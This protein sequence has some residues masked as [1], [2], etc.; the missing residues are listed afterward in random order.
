MGLVTA[1]TDRV[2]IRNFAEF[3][4]LIGAI[5]ASGFRR[6]WTYRQA[7]VAALA[8]NTMF[9][10]LRTYVMLAM[11]ALTPVVAGYT[12]PQL[13]AYVWTGQ[14]LLGV[15]MLWG[16]ADLAD[17]IRSGDVVTD[18]L[19]PIHPVLNYLAVDLG[20]AAHGMIFRFLPPVAVGVIVFDMYL[21]QDLST[22]PL[23][24]I[25]VL[26]AV[27]VCF[28]CRYL[29]NA[30]A[31]WLLDHRGVVMVWLF[32]SGLFGGLYFP[33]R[34]LP[35]WAAL[36]IW[37]GTPGPS[38]L[39]APMDIFVE[40]DPFRVQLAIVGVQV[41]WAVLMLWACHVVQRRAERKM[42]IQGG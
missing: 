8:T 33:I 25:S 31:F 5:A 16:Y 3:A 28:A 2:T 17:R 27:I 42:V 23:F 40:R 41:F 22:Y 14:G 26:L 7:T 21:P 15:V 4:S 19:R 30:S 32:V 20:R 9:G 35:Q 12:G 39:Q 36:L 38:M 1:T 29:V 24:A 34:F 37:L 11:A 6:F 10:F 13:A 18:L